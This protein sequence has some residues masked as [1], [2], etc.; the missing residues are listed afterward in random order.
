MNLNITFSYLKVVIKLNNKFKYHIHDYF[1][2]VQNSDKQTILINGS[3]LGAQIAPESISEHL[4][5]KNLDPL[6]DR[7][8]KR[9]LPPLAAVPFT[10]VSGHP[11]FK[12]SGS[13]P[14]IVH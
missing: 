6:L 13:V 9:P 4:N 5:F 11:P 14:D 12:F 1:K 2:S 10:T 7:P 8:H 3:K